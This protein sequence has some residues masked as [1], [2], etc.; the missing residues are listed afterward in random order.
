MNVARATGTQANLFVILSIVMTVMLVG[1]GLFSD[2]LE[3]AELL[4]KDTLPPGTVAYGPSSADCYKMA[5][6]TEGV[7]GPHVGFDGPNSLEERIFNSH[8]IARVRLDSV[9]SASEYGPTY[10]GM[11]HIPTLE[12]NLS[13]LDYLKGSGPSK[14]TAVWASGPT[15]DTRRG[16]EALFPAIAAQR[17]ARWDNHEAVVFLQ[18]SQTYLPSTQYADRFYLSG[19][20]YGGWGI[21]SGIYPDDYYSITSRGN[22]LWLPAEEPLGTPSQPEGDQKRFLMDTPP[23]TGPALTI[24]LGELKDRIAAVTA[25]LDAGGGSED[26]RKCVIESYR[27]ERR[28]RYRRQTDPRS[29]FKSN[30]SPPPIHQFDSGLPYGSVVYRLAEGSDITPGVPFEVWLDGQHAGLFIAD[31]PTRDY[32]VA[33]ARPLPD[34]RYSFYFNHRGPYYGQCDG[35][36]V[37]YEWT[38]NVN[39]PDGTLHE[40]FFDPVTFGDSVSADGTYGALR[41]ATFTGTHGAIATINRIAWERGDGSSGMVNVTL[42]PYDAIECQVLDFIALDGSVSLSLHVS[43]ATVDTA[44]STLSWPVASQ[45]WQSGDKLMLRIREASR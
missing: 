12:F 11:K 44:N 1:C 21:P 6:T 38:V 20:S 23:A 8:V 43:V 4:D 18:L 17:D 15:C 35:W 45:P 29:S 13:V 2:G 9:L 24:T 3:S 34:G 31:T 39:A 28:D 37:R 42:T 36:A 41:P 22:K 27:L 5:T 32:R 40:A 30:I 14:I 16:A 25:K 7:T 33:S 26:H 19:E 10:L